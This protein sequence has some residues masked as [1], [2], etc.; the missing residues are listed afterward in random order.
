MPLISTARLGSNPIRIGASTVEPNMAM[1]CCTPIRP[2][3][4][5]GRRSSGPMTPPPCS[6]EEG[7]SDQVN[8]PIAFILEKKWR[9]IK[10]ADALFGTVPW[11]GLQFTKW[12]L[13]P[14]LPD[15][16]SSHIDFQWFIPLSVLIRIFFFHDSEDWDGNMESANSCHIVL[17]INATSSITNIDILKPRNEF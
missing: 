12:Y 15:S 8:R 4:A 2:V 14:D 5:Q 6:A 1:T 13:Y 11:G 16:A 10:P 9:D 7:F 3:C 17:R